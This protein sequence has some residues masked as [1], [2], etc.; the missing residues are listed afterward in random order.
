MRLFLKKK[1]LQYSL[2]VIELEGTN[3][4]LNYDFQNKKNTW[5]K[6]KQDSLERIR[7]QSSYAPSQWAMSLQCK[8][9]SHWL[10]AYLGWSL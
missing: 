4:Y 5:S 6:L 1:Y 8:D 9:A 2:H 3:W 7:D 10:G